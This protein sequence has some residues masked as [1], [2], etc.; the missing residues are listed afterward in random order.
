M[1][2]QEII[3][4]EEAAQDAFFIEEDWDPSDAVSDSV[5]LYL[6]QIRDIPL[7]SIQ[8]EKELLSKIAAGDQNAQ[9]KLIEHNLR[10]VVSIAKR[11]RGCGI[12]FLD[13]IQ[14]GN[15]GLM[16]A[17]KKYNSER[18]TRFSTCATW[19]IRQ[20]I[21]KALTEQSRTIRI[22]GHIV[23]LLSKIKQASSIL[24][25]AKGTDPTDE[26]LAAALKVDVDKIRAAIDMSQALTSLDSPIGDDDEASYG[27]LVPDTKS[28]NALKNLIEEANRNIIES[29]FNTLS[30]REAEVLKLRFGF[31][32][33][34]PL[35]L[36]EVGQRYGVT[37]ERV[38][39]IE[40]KAMRKMRH[41][42][43][44]KVLKEAMA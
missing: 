6:N 29:V 35:T 37:R 33:N 15:V 16:N 39:Q 8:E 42:A 5:K 32:T 27:D 19:Y 2:E 1:T 28:E 9:S 14:E 13:L 22:P 38:R 12:S 20:A 43:R 34:Q 25:Q 24:F 40:T 31:D 30:S 23:D 44:M 26:E 17:A 21:S 11:Y 7:L 36:E 4:T 18:G 10:L 41:P 3:L